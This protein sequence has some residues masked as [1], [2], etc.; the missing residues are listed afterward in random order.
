MPEEKDKVIQISI[1]HIP[2]SDYVTLVALTATGR[3]FQN[4]HYY[5][6]TAERRWL[7][8]TPPDLKE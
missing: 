5:G 4:L 8:I 1:A 3:I 6:D 2:P 7:E